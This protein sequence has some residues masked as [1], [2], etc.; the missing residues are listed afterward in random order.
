MAKRYS[1]AMEY[2]R[3]DIPANPLRKETKKK[4]GQHK[5][6]IS[7]P[8]PISQEAKMKRKEIKSETKRS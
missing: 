2:T 7:N 8:I 5:I 3:H 4:Q 1:R 6:S